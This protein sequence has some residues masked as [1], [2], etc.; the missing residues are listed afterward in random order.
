[1]PE[2]DFTPELRRLMAAYEESASEHPQVGMPAWLAR[3]RIDEL[4]DNRASQQLRHLALPS[5]PFA[6]C[7][8]DALKST[9]TAQSWLRIASSWT[10]YADPDTADRHLKA[11]LFAA[12]ARAIHDLLGTMGRPALFEVAHNAALF[13][14]LSST[15]WTYQ[16]LNSKIGDPMPE[17]LLYWADL[18]SDHS[19]PKSGGDFALII[20]LDHDSCKI[21][22]LQA[23]S[24]NPRRL[25]TSDIRQPVCDNTIEQIDL[26]LENE[27][28][29]SNISAAEHGPLV[30]RWCFY[31]FWHKF[32]QGV[33]LPPIVRSAF[34]VK[35]TAPRSRKFG[36]SKVVLSGI[37][38]TP[39]GVEFTTFLVWYLLDPNSNV[40]LRCKIS[41]LPDRLTISSSS[42]RSIALLNLPAANW[43]LKYW[44]DLVN[45]LSCYTRIEPTPPYSRRVEQTPSSV[46]SPDMA[47]G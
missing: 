2:K 3:L 1:M 42:T 40:G 13:A 9:P 34:D 31:I 4:R 20:P 12:T 24:V 41:E 21:A 44:T 22:V 10:S 11:M 43:P 14:H 7:A 29:Y 47:G 35:S 32:Y 5:A 26:L 28:R 37:P 8:F 19:E 23:K 39:N 27:K 17:P 25:S 33:L 6:P 18:A 36:K 45:K 38:T 15:L 46:S 16:A 30:G